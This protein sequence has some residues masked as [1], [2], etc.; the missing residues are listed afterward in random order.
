ME[1]ENI[2]DRSVLFIDYHRPFI[3]VTAVSIEFLDS[4][5]PMR[6]TRFKIKMINGDSWVKD[7]IFIP[8]WVKIRRN[9]GIHEISNKDPYNIRQKRGVIILN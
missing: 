9:N 7:G 6:Q 2:Q 1:Q 3:Q 4:S 8:E 5:M